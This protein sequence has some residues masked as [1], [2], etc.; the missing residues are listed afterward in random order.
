M[1][2]PVVSM[3]DLDKILAQWARLGAMFN[4]R[5]ARRTPDIEQL[6]TDTAAAVSSFARLHAMTVSW[7]V[8]YHRLVCRHRLSVL[9]SQIGHPKQSAALGYILTLAKEHE[10]V[11]HFNLA[12]KACRPLPKP[13]PLF[14]VYLRNSAMVT[15]AKKQAEPISKRWGLWAPSERLYT[16]AI[17]PTEW[18]MNKNPSLEPR[19]VFG[20]K[21]PASILVVLRNNPDAGQ[22]ESALSRT[23]R[24]TR[25]SI[26]DA[27]E[28]LELCRRI[29]RRRIGNVTHV[30]VRE[31]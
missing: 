29:H 7:L 20:G 19:A 26:R 14:D 10:H 8:R 30:R 6:L 18:V 2:L 16:D 28:H 4:V 15:L 27:L 17:R 21:L 24:A 9:A 11:D 22:S 13:Q 23:C 5:M 31:T 25:S 3:P 12:I 1:P